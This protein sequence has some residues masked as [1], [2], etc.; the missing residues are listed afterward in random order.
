M[1]KVP[2][3]AE[4]LDLS[5]RSYGYR[6]VYMQQVPPDYIMEYLMRRRVFEIQTGAINRPQKEAISQDVKDRIIRT[7]LEI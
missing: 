7:R 4:V 6:F 5:Y 3:G 2:E 1:P